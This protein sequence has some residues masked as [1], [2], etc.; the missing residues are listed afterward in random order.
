MY[1]KERSNNM[2]GDIRKFKFWC[3]KVLP[4]VY[5]DSLSYYEVLCKVVN[6]LNK[7][8]EDINS[9]PD[10]IDAVIMSHLDDEHLKELIL[11]VMHTIEDAISANNETENNSSSDYNVG[12]LI[13][14]K[15]VLYKVIRPIDAG[16]SFVIGTNIEASNIADLFATFVKSVKDSISDNDEGLNTTASR[17]W[18]KGTWLWLNDKLYITLNNITEGT[19]YVTS[20]SSA[21]VQLI[22]IEDIINDIMDNVGELSNL[23]TTDKTNIVNA[24]NE[25]VDTIGNL[26]ELE[27]TDKSTIVNA[28]NEVIQMISDIPLPIPLIVTPEM[29]GAVGDGVTDD[30]E[31]IQD[32]INH[33]E[34]IELN[35]SYYVS[36]SI[37]VGK[38]KNLCGKGTIISNIRDN[39]I[40]LAG[41][42][43]VDGLSFTDNLPY[44]ASS[45]NVIYAIDTKYLTVVNCT[46][47]TIGNGACIGFEHCEHII[48]K[49]NVLLNYGHS[50]I[51]LLNT[52]YYVDIMF[53][54]LTTARY[55]GTQH[56]YPITIS[57]YTSYD[58]GV[59]RY[60]RCNYNEI[61]QSDYEWEGID[62]HGCATYEIIG[63]TIKGVYCGIG[64]G[65]KRTSSDTA[66]LDA[67]CEAIIKDNYIEAGGYNAQGIRITTEASDV[68]SQDIEIANNYI[69]INADSTSADSPVVSAISL[70]SDGI[71]RS[72]TVKNNTIRA[73][74]AHCIALDGIFY[75]IDIDSNYI[76]RFT[77]ASG[78]N[79]II[80]MM[81][82][83]SFNGVR[84]HDNCVGTGIQSGIFAKGPNV[85][86]INN[87]LV[88][89]KDNNINR[90]TFENITYNTAPRDNLSNATKAQGR[91]GLF[92]E[93]TDTTSTVLGWYSKGANKWYSVTGTAV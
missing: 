86:G 63:N 18:D 34:I 47:S 92:I 58:Y 72:V 51:K 57:G 91:L 60:I 53:N 6:Y 74:N 84:I 28:I 31:A 30:T 81:Q 20:G 73:Y 11:E 69:A 15:G 82:I 46:F 43:I 59:A 39:I 24:I 76:N 1:G 50:G 4:L 38:G 64:L 77:S 26:A 85:A 37:T 7:I 68:T 33:G 70:R 62:S 93:N 67:N 48:I 22:T 83:D 36:S 80:H 49:H 45:G 27:T 75:N 13:W 88:E 61:T 19:A 66:F 35:N 32:A 23:S 29:F 2:I 79:A 41:N 21:N 89:I 5:D 3:Q 78:A 52:C 16:D 12:E 8:I 14:W 54:K 25:I 71:F 55:T 40:I 17:D 9:I 42:N 44:D 90:T 56:N 65:S 10:Y 87:D